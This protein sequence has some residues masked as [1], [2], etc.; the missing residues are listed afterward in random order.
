MTPKP[1]ALGEL[2]REVLRS[3][4]NPARV[5]MACL[6]DLWAEAAGPD[7]A[8]KTRVMGVRRGTLMVS[9]GSSA[10]KSEIEAYR[11]PEILRKLEDRKSVV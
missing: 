3:I 5:T 8:V 6:S 2:T 4:S 1:K 11:R 7:V 10:L 9:T